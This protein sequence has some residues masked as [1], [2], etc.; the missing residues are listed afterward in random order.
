MNLENGLV[1]Y[2]LGWWRGPES[3]GGKRASSKLQFL[4]MFAFEV[5]ERK[6]RELR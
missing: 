2:L 4:L 3:E 5:R 6:R 1:G